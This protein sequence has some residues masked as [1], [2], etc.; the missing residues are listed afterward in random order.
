MLKSPDQK[1]PSYRIAHCGHFPH[2]KVDNLSLDN[3]NIVYLV[4]VGKEKF[5][6]EW[7]KRFINFVEDIKPQK[8]FIV[9]ADSLQ[10]FNLEVDENLSEEQAMQ[11]ANLRGE[12][13]IEKYKPHFSILGQSYEFI[14]WEDLKSNKDYI[15][16]YNS[17]IDLV[18]SDDYFKESLL[19]SSEEYI[20]RPSRS[21]K[22]KILALEKSSEFLKEECA[23]LRI[24][25]KVKNTKVILYPGKA[26]DVLHYAIQKINVWDRADYPMHWIELKPTKN[27]K[28]NSKVEIKNTFFNPAP[29]SVSYK[30][31]EGLFEKSLPTHAL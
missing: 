5:E 31:E 22:D 28:I 1:K 13:W 14:R 6:N 4:S 23:V 20:N 30:D 10:R 15:L 29:S 12:A 21:E 7:V 26:T 19:K 24:L 3:I 11:E 17:V 18:S 27:K 2:Y 9:V 16:F 8:T 25:S